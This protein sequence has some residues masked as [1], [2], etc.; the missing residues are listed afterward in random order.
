M[1]D[2]Q[3]A[4]HRLAPHLVDMDVSDD[5]VISYADRRFVLFHTQMFARLFEQ[6]AEVTGPAIERKITEFGVHAG[7]RIASKMD[8]AFSDPSVRDLLRLLV[9]SGGDVGALLAVRSTDTQASIEKILGYGM[10]AG[11]NG[12]VAIVT[13]AANEELVVHAHNPFEADSYGETGDQECAFILGALKGILLYYWD[14]DELTV[15][16][17]TC[18]CDGSDYCR[19]VVQRA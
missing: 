15:M 9:A 12:D 5:G 17:E 2:R 3:R 18:E 6:M 4:F 13:Y 11:W 8:A 14:V 7:Q 1:T 16:E 10:Y 19:I